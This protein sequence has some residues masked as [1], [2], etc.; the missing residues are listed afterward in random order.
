MS[1][2]LSTE[3]RAEAERRLDAIVAANGVRLLLAV[4]S[5]SR[6]WGFPSPDSDYDV[7]F[8]YVRPLETY[9][10]LSPP[11]DVIEAPIEG[12]WDVNGWDLSKALRLL[13]KGN[14]VIVEWL[15]SPLVYRDGGEPVTAMRRLAETFADTPGSIR[16]YFGLLHGQ[17]R[18]DFGD[19]PAVKLKKYFYAVRAASALA[20]LRE[21]GAPAP[22]ALPQL[23]EG[24]VVPADVQ[25][26]L[27]PLLAVKLATHE[28]GEGARVA[29]LDH[30]CEAMQAWAIDS[31]ALTPGPP[32][33][34]LIAAT[35]ALFLDVA[36]GRL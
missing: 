3:A 10:S 20:W 15:R 7:R 8:V 16:H 18:R 13:R 2:F 36:L 6:A 4:E 25:E 32:A 35:D 9:L 27:A 14:A 34:D 1:A 28:V 21:H 31:G 29:V 26:A 23:L 11:R 17:W 19:R 12:L 33:L 22:M 5:G 30:F 24:G